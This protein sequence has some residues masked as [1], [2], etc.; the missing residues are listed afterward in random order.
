MTGFITA[1]R[2]LTIIPVSGRE[3]EKL[4]SSLAWFP[5]VG[6]LLGLLLFGFG[7]LWNLLV[8]DWP[9]GGAILVLLA[10]IYLTRGLHLDGLA[11]WADATGGPRNREARLAIMK[12]SHLGT[13]G[14]I[15]LI[16]VLLSKWVALER[17]LHTDSLLGVLPAMVVSRSMMVELIA[18]LPYARPDSGMAKPFVEG[19]MPRQRV[20]SHVIALGV[21][22]CFGPM[23]TALFFIGWTGARLLATIFQR[24]FNGITGDLLGA[25]NEIVETLLLM[26]WALPGPFLLCYTGWKW[27]I[28]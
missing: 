5:V 3:S 13:F 26:I 11:D 2:T 8:E 16:L 23:G 4:S 20:W 14:V 28:P 9:G 7:T 18:L 22:L 10:D 27:I 6:L 12:D 19:I 15:A 25:T 24:M 1:I 21:C 17:V